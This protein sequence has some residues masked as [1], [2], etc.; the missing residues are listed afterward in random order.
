[1]WNKNFKKQILKG[2]DYYKYCKYMAKKDLKKNEIIWN[3]M[4]M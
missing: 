1:M 2:I 3:S 4:V